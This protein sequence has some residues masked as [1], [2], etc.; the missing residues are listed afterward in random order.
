MKNVK[1]FKRFNESSSSDDA[2]KSCESLV[3]NVKAVTDKYQPM[4]DAEIKK[5]LE[6]YKGVDPSIIKSMKTGIKFMLKEITM[7]A[8]DLDFETKESKIISDFVATAKRIL[9]LFK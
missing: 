8:N 3:K 1:N 7:N 6:I 4:S 5:E 2:N 9:K